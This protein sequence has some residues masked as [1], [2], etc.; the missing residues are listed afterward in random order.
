MSA[1]PSVNPSVLGDLLRRGEAP[2]LID[3][4][5]PIEFA[6]VHARSARNM[7]LDRLD[8]KHVDASRPAPDRPIYVLCKSGGRAAK[9]VE[10]LSAAGVDNVLL[11]EG[12]TDAWIRAGL[13]VER[14]RSV[15]SLERQVRIVAGSLVLI[16]VI[17]GFSVHRG[18]FGLSAFI[19]AGL[20]FAGVTNFCGMGM[21]LAKAPWNRRATR[22]A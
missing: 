10:Q 14:D 19:G 13:P 8:P 12:G 20:V 15:I 9:A 4:R 6:E 21:L 5:T 16:G 1:V 17:L 22:D 18:F 2:A 7:P 3:V 11:I